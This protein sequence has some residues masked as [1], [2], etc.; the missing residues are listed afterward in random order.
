MRRATLLVGAL[1]LALGAAL[2]GGI[3]W[4]AIPAVPGGVIQGCYDAGGNVKVVSALPC[5][6]GFTPFQW[7][8]Q[9]PPGDTGPSMGFSA[10]ATA[11]EVVGDEGTTILSKSVP[12]GDYVLTARIWVINWA[13]EL[14]IGDCVIPGDAP[15][16]PFWMQTSGRGFGSDEEFTLTSAIHH[17]GGPIAL[18]CKEYQGQLSVLS[19]SMSGIKVG[20]IG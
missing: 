3:A 6:K 17:S 15:G 20:E 4:A 8:Q 14:A 11:T 18:T 13:E 10:S 16:A 5:P 2:A 12:E 9:G 1:G 19:A 7:N